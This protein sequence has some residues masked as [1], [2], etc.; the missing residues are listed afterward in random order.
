VGDLLLVY[1]N[2]AAELYDMNNTN[3]SNRLY[4]VR[5]FENDGNRIVLRKS[6]NAQQEKQLG[7]GESIKDFS[8]MPEKIRC[9]INT[10][11]YILSGKDFEMLSNGKI[12][13]L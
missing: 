4:V 8:N 2:E 3:L 9:G 5:G 12:K 7:K 1:K 10:L 13:F 11:K 6:I